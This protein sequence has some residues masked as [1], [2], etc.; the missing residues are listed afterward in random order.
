MLLLLL[1]VPADGV[2]GPRLDGEVDAGPMSL[3]LLSSRLSLDSED[4]KRR[5]VEETTAAG[6]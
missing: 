5:V 6:D 2:G 3:A 4:G 1:L